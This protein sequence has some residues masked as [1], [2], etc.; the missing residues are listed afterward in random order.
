[1]RKGLIPFTVAALAAGAVQVNGQ[2][3]PERIRAVARASVEVAKVERYQRRDREEQTEHF[4]KT[5]RIGAN[6][7]IDISNI[8]GDITITRGGGSDATIEVVKTSRGRSVEDARSM[9]PLVRVDINERGG[10]VEVRTHYP[11]DDERRINNR[12]NINV[13]VA[14]TIRV[15]GETGVRAE[16]I[17]GNIN[18]RD[19]R[20]ELTL[21]SISGNIGIANGGRITQAKSI[22]GNVE[23]SS[24]EIDSASNISSVSGNVTVRS[25][26]ARR[27]D[28][29]SVSGN[30]IVDDVT[31]DRVQAQTTS[32]NVDFRGTLVRGGRYD[33]QSHSGEVH[34]GVMGD[35]G[36]ELDASS[37][38]GQVRSD[39]PIAIQ[40]GRGRERRVQRG[41]YGDGSAV[42]H[43]TTFS[44][45]IAI[46][47]R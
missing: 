43:L 27:L 6:G 40:G 41:T 26:K 47:K 9:L 38:S 37:F 32:G 1:M 19:L 5:V 36:F 16:S 45:N 7:Q 28:L 18:V 42:L 8:A 14:Y 31:C 23:I 39:L 30:I 24:T 25:L 12:R 29:A 20:G 33:L 10:R 44:G 21:S 22:S 15:P 2:V 11:D 46:T 4:T 3:Y 35:T 13:S 17:S 34:V